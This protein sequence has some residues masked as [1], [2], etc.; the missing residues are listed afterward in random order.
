MIAHAGVCAGLI[1]LSVQCLS[2]VADDSAASHSAGQIATSL[3][4]WAYHTALSKADRSRLNPDNAIARL[5]ASRSLLD[6]RASVHARLDDAEVV[7][8][9]RL[10][11]EDASSAQ[12]NEAGG[13]FNFSQAYLR[14]SPA[15]RVTLT[16]GRFRFTWGP[17][18]FRSPGNP[19]YFDSGKN[20]PL[21]DVPGVDMLRA[22]VSAAN[23]RWTLAY[24]ANTRY[25]DQRTSVGSATVLKAD[26]Q[27]PVWMAGLSAAV[28]PDGAPFIGA[29]AQYLVDDALMFYGE[30]GHGARRDSLSISPSG[31]I[32]YGRPHS[33]ANR[34]STALVGATY[35]LSN[36][37]ALSA[38]YLYD[39]HGF[40]ID[41]QE[42]YFAVAAESAQA[43]RTASSAALRAEEATLLRRLLAQAPALLGRH[44]GYLLWQSNPQE[45]A[46]YWRASI[47]C[48]LR[49]QSTQA[50]LY[51]EKSIFRRMSIFG[52]AMI[53]HGTVDTEFGAIASSA[54]SIGAKF[55]IF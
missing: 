12:T 51:A 21:R 47:A 13:A 24:V 40:S 48:N 36:G 31:E 2:A 46:L 25:L 33:R 30:Y 18:N 55:Y 41:E 4:L 8:Q 15:Q 43:F 54:I 37:Q 28:R 53:N 14:H 3:D 5:P 16:G 44:Y 49:D 26:L 17:A 1:L 27:G 23:T 38:E 10:L 34:A 39:G 22:D 20:Q 35:T 6:V 45:S 9:P 52:S 32:R 42:R 19:F 11:V 50:L 29:I 7:L